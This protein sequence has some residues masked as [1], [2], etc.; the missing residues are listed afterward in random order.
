MQLETYYD[1]SYTVVSLLFLAPFVGYTCAALLNHFIHMN[2]GQRGLAFIAPTCRLVA[3]IITCLHPPYPVLPIVFMLAGLG[4]GLE[5]GGYNAWIGN[6]HRANELL[7]IL[8]AAYGLGATISPLI[9]TSMVAKRALPWYTFYYVMIGIAIIELL[10]AV[11]AFWGATAA[12][13]RH[14]H[15]KSPP[16]PDHTTHRPLS[17]YKNSIT[18]ICAIF[19]LCYVG[20]EVSIGGWVVTFML[21]IRHGSAYASGIVETGF[22]LGMTMGR[23]ILGFVTGRIGEKV[24][25]VIYLVAGMVLE[26]LFWSIPSFVAS[27][28]MVS[29]L[30]FFLAPMFPAAVVVATKLL[31]QE[32]HVSA[33]GFAAAFGGGGAALFPFMVGAIAQVRGVQALQPIVLV[34]L[35]LC[36]LLWCILP[37]GFGKSGLDQPSEDISNGKKPT[38]QFRCFKQNITNLRW[39]SDVG[40][41]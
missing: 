3:Y 36:L 1:I 37:G 25:I 13:H 2:L 4:N 22:W 39:R 11:T 28:V 29:F 21:R 34:L 41:V 26:L 35:V 15:P 6:M 24:A 16:N 10:T 7:G 19:L 5:D 27:A 9:A 32:L 40:P 17:V 12:V 8:H 14:A 38:N 33:V 23:L 18:W 20:I 30:G 31:P